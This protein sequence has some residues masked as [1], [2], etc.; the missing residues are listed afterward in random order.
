M[1]KEDETQH[2]PMCEEW[3]KRSEQDTKDYAELHNK[4]IKLERILCEIQQK[5]KDIEFKETFAQYQR[6][7]NNFLVNRLYGISNNLLESDIKV[8]RGMNKTDC[9]NPNNIN[10]EYYKEY[11]QCENQ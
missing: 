9:K 4:Y 7:Q 10:C 1:F 5:L 11:N 3:A 6:E 2:C 8:I